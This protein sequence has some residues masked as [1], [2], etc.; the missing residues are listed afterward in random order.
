MAEEEFGR[1]KFFSLNRPNYLWEFSPQYQQGIK[2]FIINNEKRQAETENMDKLSRSALEELDFFSNLNDS[3]I[4]YANS[5][6]ENFFTNS[7]L[8]M[9]S[10]NR[11]MNYSYAL[12]FAAGL[13]FFKNQNF[14]T[15]GRLCALT[16]LGLAV[17][18]LLFNQAKSSTTLSP[19]ERNILRTYAL[20]SSIQIRSTNIRGFGS[21]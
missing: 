7:G 13:F 16:G 5:S 1:G 20:L 12:P 18:C 4:K 19:E 17:S 15:Y 3:L 10:F 14:T 21:V 9:S 6:N 11:M 8:S 2:P